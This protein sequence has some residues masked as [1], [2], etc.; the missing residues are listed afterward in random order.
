LQRISVALDKPTRDGDSEIHLLTNLPE[1]EQALVLAMLYLER[2]Q[3]ENLF[4]E[5]S[6]ALEAEVNTLCYPKAAL[7]DFCVGLLTYNTISVL[8][9]ALYAAHGEG[10][11]VQRLSTYYL[12]EEIDAVYTGMMIAIPATTWTRTFRDLSSKQVAAILQELAAGTRVKRFRKR[13]RSTRKPPPKRTG[14]LREKHVSTQ[15]LLL[16]R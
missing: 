14:G 12:A 15:R 10:A 4:G 2:W 8:K 3:I 13:T 11:E 16:R 6:Q 5:L 9:S 7:L 1:S